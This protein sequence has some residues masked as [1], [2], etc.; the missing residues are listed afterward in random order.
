MLEYGVPF[1]SESLLKNEQGIP[2]PAGLPLHAKHR[3]YH[4]RGGGHRQWMQVC[5]PRQVRFE[6]WELQTNN[7]PQ[8]EEQNLLLFKPR[9][10]SL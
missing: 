9:Q 1:H 7:H 4:I 8:E 3:G 5:S 2:V 10:E 6:L